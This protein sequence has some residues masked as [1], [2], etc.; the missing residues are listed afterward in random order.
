MARQIKTKILMV[1]LSTALGAVVLLSI[2]GLVSILNMRRITLF[3]SDQLGSTAA[4]ESQVALEAQV[5]NQ[6][7]SLA[8]DRAALTDE[9]LTAIQNQ[10]R[11]I[12]DIATQIYTYRD[13]Y[14]PKF[15]DYLRA[16]QNG[17]LIPHVATAAGISI[18]QF[19]DEIYRAANI[20]DSL[21]QMT[22]LDIG[23]T[24]SYIGTE[25]GF[26]IIVERDAPPIEDN[27][28]ARTRAWYRGTKEK[29]GLFWSDIIADA[30]TNTAGISC[31]MPFYDLS[32]GGKV[33]KGVAG[34]GTLLSENVNKIIDS[35]K[36]GETGYA[37]LLNEKGHVIMSPKNEDIV[38]SESGILIGEDYLGN[39]N[40]AVRELARRMVDRESGLMELN[41]DG[42][43]VYVA[44]HPLTAIGWSLGVVAAIDEIIAPARLIQQDILSLTKEATAG[45]DHTILLIVLMV[46]AVII[47]AAAVTILVAVRLSNSL[48]A[49]I[50]SLS[51]GAKII[52]GGDLNYQL[53]VKTGDEIEMLADTFNNMIRDIKQITGEKERIGAEL[54]VA[55]T[56]QASMLPS[57]FPPFPHRPEFDI[58]AVM[59]PAKE[60][61]GDFYDFFMVDEDNLAVIIADVSGKGVPAALFMVIAKTLLKNNAQMG[62]PLDEIFYTVNNQLCENNE[63]RSN[64]F[65]TAFMG[66]LNIST[67]RFSYV[68]AGHNP[69]LVRQGNGDFTWLNVKAGLMLACME[70]M[71]FKVMEIT[72][73]KNDIVFLYT[74][75][76]TEA[77]N[78]EEELFGNDRMLTA[79][80]ADAV[81][82]CTIQEY[83][84][85]MLGEIEKFA[86]G[87]DQAD[88]ITMLMLQLK[89]IPPNPA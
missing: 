63:A 11:M 78:K 84:P 40:P 14:A 32:N 59:C 67:G 62:K 24:A 18:A 89:I 21:R 55:T 33:F 53:E 83:I 3:H 48:T 82:N 4:G 46:I 47:L 45:I 31:A 12:A 10:T 60:V 65:V 52:S 54:N 79:L 56:I 38:V 34:S 29:E 2:T 88:D 57:I 66:L 30:T 85:A 7:V 8:Q 43:N 37:F 6:L 74:D 64:M 9:K 17:E 51:N 68:N 71:R 1:I 19:R 15:I 27:Y 28:D 49:P 72:L 13:R 69:P 36:I 87:A 22:V 35:T 50:L 70:D 16:G 23:L 75:G 86:N 58:Y 20:G 73:D 61:G 77:L 39:E 44:Y 81:K 41:L 80:N 42:R 26:S 25:S 5:R 76:V